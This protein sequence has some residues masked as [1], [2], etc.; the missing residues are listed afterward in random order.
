MGDLWIHVDPFSI[1]GTIR[2]FRPKHSEKLQVG[3]WIIR[4]ELVSYYACVCCARMEKGL[5]FWV[6]ASCDDV[7]FSN[8]IEG[9][10]LLISEIEKEHNEMATKL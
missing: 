8:K 3:D 4:V 5:W 10:K 1:G 9:N 7:D 6:Y 2:F